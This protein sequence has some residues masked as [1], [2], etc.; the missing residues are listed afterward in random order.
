LSQ[1]APR[2]ETHKVLKRKALLLLKLHSKALCS[3][4]LLNNLFF[5]TKCYYSIVLRFVYKLNN[6]KPSN[7][8]AKQQSSTN[9][10]L[11]GGDLKTRYELTIGDYLRFYSEYGMRK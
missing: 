3:F 10:P 7:H 6:Y 5:T 4:L 8:Q 1:S 2:S 9:H 11:Q